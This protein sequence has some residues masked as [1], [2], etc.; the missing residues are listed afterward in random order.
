MKRTAIG[1]GR[2]SFYTIYGRRLDQAKVYTLTFNKVTYSRLS[3]GHMEALKKAIESTP[4]PKP[5]ELIE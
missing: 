2:C 4:P 1:R 3:A 5:N